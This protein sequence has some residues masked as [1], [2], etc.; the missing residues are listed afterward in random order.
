[1]KTEQRAST[2][3]PL[4]ARGP[5]TEATA[6]PNSPPLR[7]RVADQEG[8]ELS[9]RPRAG[10]GGGVPGDQE[11]NVLKRSLG[12]ERRAVRRAAGMT[13]KVL[14]ARAGVGLRSL[15]DLETGRR[16]PSLALLGALAVG[17]TRT[18]PPVAGLDPAPVRARLIA[19]AGMSAVVDTLGGIRRRQRRLRDAHLAYVRDVH[20]WWAGECAAAQRAEIAFV[21]AISILDRPGALDDANALLAAIQQMDVHRAWANQERRVRPPMWTTSAFRRMARAHGYQVHRGRKG[22]AA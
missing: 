3:T 15:G 14:A 1:M 17:S 5:V 6:G 7:R 21:T 18:I 19:A 11:R 9:P 4:R 12:A 13:Q 2:P 8:W 10:R 20:A 22:R 16:R